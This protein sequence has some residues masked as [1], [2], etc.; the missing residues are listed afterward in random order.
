MSKSQEKLEQASKAV[1]AACRALVR[2][3]QSLIK[4]RSQ[5]ED[6]VDYSKLGAH[7]FKVREMEQ[8]V[9]I[10]QLENA[11]ASA[12]HRLGEMRK[13]SYQEE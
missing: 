1:G 10:L 13:I 9:E 6:Q 2:Q 11:L 4:E 5:E 3:V 7:E 8:Q 12:R